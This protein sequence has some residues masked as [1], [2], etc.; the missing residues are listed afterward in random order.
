MKKL[1][2]TGIIVAIALIIFIF[3]GPFFII[4]EGQQ[5]VVI[6][7]GKIQN[8]VKEAGLHF[9]MPVTDN[10]VVYSE[11]ILAWDGDP[12]RIPTA[13][14][15]FIWVD[16]TARWHITEPKQ[17]Y[18]SVTSMESGYARLD[19]VIDSAVRTVISGNPLHEAVRDSNIINK[20]ERGEDVL[21]TAKEEVEDEEELQELQE[22]TDI[23]K[24]YESVEQGRQ[25]LS[26]KMLDEVK[27]VVPSFGMEVIDVVIRQI[28]YSDDLTQSVYDRMIAQRKQI[29]AAFRSHGRGKKLEWLGK[30]EREK[31]TILSEAYRTSEEIRGKADAKAANTYA[32]AYQQDSNFFEFYRS[33]ESYR[34]TMPGFEKILTTELD[35][36]DFLQSQ[37]GNR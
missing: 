17:F 28:R 23:N 9:K 1:Y 3:L 13:E 29:A 8:V 22:L 18:E 31:K 35:Y 19:D 26:E 30:L 14:N 25:T 4:E 33:M 11:K 16:T 24:T 37:E 7:F 6:R 12:Q 34:K 32:N 5:A 10:V 36:F 21:K 27:Q 15:Q 2:T 20:M